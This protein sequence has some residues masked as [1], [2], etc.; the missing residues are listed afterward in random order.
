MSYLR[1]HYEPDVLLSD[2]FLG[3]P[4]QTL[5]N[6]AF[7]PLSSTIAKKL[8]PRWAMFLGMCLINTGFLIM[9]FS[10]N[11]ILTMLSFSMFHGLGNSCSFMAPV[12][13]GWA[14]FPER[15]G[16]AAG[17]AIAGVGVGGFAYSIIAT[18]LI[19]PDNLQGPIPVPDGN[20]TDNFFEGNVA[21]RFP[22]A[23][24]YMAIIFACVTILAMI[25]V[26]MP[27]K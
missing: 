9:S 3:I 7:M 8:S 10:H 19:N 15:K 11:H 1:L 21:N 14:Y 20:N 2:V 26:R 22:A 23:C 25:F 4:I 18:H 16:M 24:R 13:A 6:G 17:V 5:T 27:S 12:I